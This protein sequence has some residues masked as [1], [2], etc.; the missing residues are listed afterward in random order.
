MTQLHAW[1][2]SDYSHPKLHAIA[3]YVEKG[4]ILEDMQRFG[5]I[6]LDEKGLPTKEKL[7]VCWRVET[8]A[9]KDTAECWKDR[10]L[11][12]AFNSYYESLQNREKVYCMVSGAYAPPPFSI[13]KKSSQ[14][15]EM[16]MPS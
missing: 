5:L 14:P 2:N 4:T 15:G 1:E 13:R 7:V 10:S 12:Q 16:P 8:G 11:F 9:E 3:R 6:S